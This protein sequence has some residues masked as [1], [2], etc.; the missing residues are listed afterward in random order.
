MTPPK[1]CAV[2]LNYKTYLDTIACAES[3]L[4]QNYSNFCI[5]IVENGSNNDSLAILTEKYGSN[6]LVTILESNENIGFAKGNNIGI[7]YAKEKLNCDYVFVANSDVIIENNLFFQISNVSIENIGVISP[8]VFNKDGTYQMPAENND[9]IYKRIRV[10][11]KG[12][13]LRKILGF[14]VIKKMYKHFKAN[15]NQTI[16]L[17]PKIW[18]KN[19]IQ[20]CSYFLT[21]NFFQYYRQLYP[22]TFLYWEEINLLVYLE[23]VGLRA[24]L[25]DT[26]TV[27]H[28][29]KSATKELLKNLDLDKQVFKYCVYS[30]FQSLP[31][32]FMNYEKIKKKYN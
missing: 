24:I 2:I 16:F 22:K 14:P 5:V 15:K 6:G 30:M 12:I 11:I 21:P 31:M 7:L 18:K 19:V 26:S 3:V 1:I 20:G 29:E 10:V 8:T 23:K 4:K 9:D 28:K 17:V 13:Y 32:F 25:V 27:I